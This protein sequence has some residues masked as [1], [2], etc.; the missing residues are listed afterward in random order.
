[1]DEDLI[2]TQIGLIFSQVR[3]LRMA[4]DQVERSTARY[5]GVAMDVAAAG[6]RQWG[7]P[8]LEGGSLRV[9]VINIQDLISADNSFL[10]VLSSG[11]RL[12]TSAISGLVGGAISGLAL[13]VILAEIADIAH[14]ALEILHL[15][16]LTGGKEKPGKPGESVPQ[17]SGTLTAFLDRLDGTATKI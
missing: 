7:A 2:V 11:F 14:T 3:Y 17:Q 10:G 16:G 13:P 9:F 4:F 1:M 6:P 5:A 12:V 15:L 8:P